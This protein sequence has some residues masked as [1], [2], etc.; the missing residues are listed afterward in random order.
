MSRTIVGETNEISGIDVTEYATD[1]AAAASALG[2]GAWRELN[3]KKKEEQ[4]K[5]KAEA[6]AKKAAKEKEKE[7]KKAAK[8]NEP[9]AAA[10]KTRVA[11]ASKAGAKKKAKPKLKAKKEK[12]KISYVKWEKREH[13]HGWYAA[14][15]KCFE[16]DPNVMDP[17]WDHFSDGKKVIQ[18][19]FLYFD[20]PYIKYMGCR[21]SKNI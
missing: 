5:K 17:R 1:D 2:T 7:E 4:V 21:G 3:V 20:F 10:K 14:R 15:A 9:I 13:W 8:E 19:I 16:E 11:A 18:I 6:T 12:G